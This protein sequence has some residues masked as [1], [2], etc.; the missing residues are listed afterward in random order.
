MNKL[1]N[2]KDHECQDQYKE[3]VVAQQQTIDNRFN[4]MDIR[5]LLQLT[6]HPVQQTNQQPQF[7]IRAAEQPSLYRLLTDIAKLSSEGKN[8]GSNSSRK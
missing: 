5:Q 1:S 4:M 8:L 3:Q 2:F 7:Q 6:Q